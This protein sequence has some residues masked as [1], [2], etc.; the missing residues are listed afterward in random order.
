MN[1]SDFDILNAC[2]FTGR[3]R[4]AFNCLGFTGAVSCDILPTEIPGK[5]YQGDVR[6]LLREHWHVIISHPPCT[7][8]ANSGVR[9]LYNADGSRYKERW[10]KM[11]EGAEFFKKI[12]D[13]PATIGK[14]IE[15]PVMHK[16]AKKIIGRSHDQTFQPWQFGHPESKRTC[17]WLD[18]L[19]PLIPSHGKCDFEEIGQSV[20]RMSPGKDRAKKR[21][22]TPWHVAGAMAQ[23]WGKY[24]LAA[25]DLKGEAT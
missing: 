6:D 1:K 10:K 17:L 8:L 23:D 3:V 13:T 12:L 5:H 24:I 7:Y 20:H 4:E 15:N 25:A 2:E 14:A 11:R 9:W 21:S 18:R 22:E 16:Y 19:P